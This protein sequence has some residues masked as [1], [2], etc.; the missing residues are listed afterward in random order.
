MTVSMAADR[1]QSPAFGGPNLQE[2]SKP[3]SGFTPL[4]PIRRTS[5][6]D[7]LTRKKLGG[8]ED[9]GTPSPVGSSDNE[10]PPVPPIKDGMNYQNG[11]GHIPSQAHGDQAAAHLNQPHSFHQQPPPQQH[12]A[13]ANGQVPIPNGFPAGRGAAQVNGFHP[14][15]ISMGRGGPVGPHPQFNQMQGQPGPLPM[16]NA[17]QPFISQM[18]GNPIHKFPP[19]GQWKLEESVLSEPLIQHKRPGANSP[20]Q[21]QPGYFALD[22]ETEEASPPVRAQ[23]GPQT[24]PRNNSSNIPPVSAERFRKHNIFAPH[25]PEQ[26]QQQLPPQ[27]VGHPL[28]QGQANNIPNQ[29]ERSARDAGL[30]K[31]PDVRVDEVSVSSVTSEEPQSGGGRRG[32]GFFSLTNRRN[33]GAESGSQNSENASGKEKVSFFGAM[34]NHNKFQPKQK[35]NLGLPRTSTFDHDD[36]PEPASMKKRLSELT[37]MI[38]GVGNAKDGAKDDQPVKPSG[39]YP[40]RPS[41]QGPIRAQTGFQPPQG[42]HGQLGFSGAPSNGPGRSS[43]GGPRPPEAQ[44]SQG[45]DDREKKHGFLG[46]FFNRQGFKSSDSRQ[47]NSPTPPPGQKPPPQFPMQPGQQFRP[48]QMPPPGQGQFGP[49]PM[50]A[51]QPPIQEGLPGQQGMRRPMPPG[52]LN[53]PENIQSPTSPQFLGTAQAVMI[54][55]PSEITVSSQSQVGGSQLSPGQRSQLSQQGSLANIRPGTGQQ[56][57]GEDFSV[58]GALPKEA[59]RLSHQSSRDRL[60]GGGSPLATRTTPTRKPVGS[61]SRPDGTS[62]ASGQ[63]PPNSIQQTPNSTRAGDPASRPESAED[64]RRSSSH[65]PSGQQSPTLG[66]LG[67]VRQTSLP[68][69]GRPPMLSQPGQVTSPTAT[70]AQLSPLGPMPSRDQQGLG[71]QHEMSQG[72][73]GMSQPGQGFAGYPTSLSGANPQHNPRQNPQAWGPNVSFANPQHPVSP[74]QNNQGQPPR[75]V[76][77]PALAPDQQSTISKFFG[78][79]GNGKDKPTRQHPPPKESKEKSAAS[80]FLDAFKRGSKQSEPNPP[81]PQQRPPPG[82]QTPPNMVRTQQANMNM[83]RPPISGPSPAGPL[84]PMS[85]PQGPMQPG[86][87][88]GVPQPQGPPNLGPMGPPM[89]QGAGRGE[90]PPQMQAGR[91]QQMMMVFRPQGPGQG[92]GAPGQRTEPQYDMVPIPRGYEAVHGYGNAGMLAPSPYNV[93]RPSPPPPQP[94][95]QAFVPQGVPQGVPQQWGPRQMPPG[96]AYGQHPALLQPGL[97]GIPPQA[98]QRQTDSESSTPTPSEQGT[99]LDMAPTPPPQQPQDDFRFDRPAGQSAPAPAQAAH[100]PGPQ[101]AQAGAQG[102]P[103]QA[104]NTELQTPS[105]SNWGSAPDSARTPQSQRK[106]DPPI[107]TN[108]LH[109]KPSDPNVSPPS[110]SDDVQRPQHQHIA[111]AMSNSHPSILQPGTPQ[112]SVPNSARAFSPTGGPRLVQ[113]SHAPAVQEPES[114]AGRLVSKMS[115]TA[116]S[117]TPTPNSG[118][119]TPRNANGNGSLSPDILGNRATSVS[120]EPRPY[121]QV[122][123]AS[124]NINV[125]RAN[126]LEKG[127]EDDLY[128]A[129]PRMGSSKHVPAP[130][131]KQQQQHPVQPQQVYVPAQTPIQGPVPVSV[132]GHENTKYAGTAVNGAGIAGVAAGA[133]AGAGL[134]AGVIME[135]GIPEEPTPPPEQQMRQQQ[136]PTSA[137]P[138]EKIL[139]DQPAELPAVHDDDDG[140][141]V[142]SATSYPGQEWNPYGAGEFGDWD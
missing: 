10:I 35:S 16:H 7:L 81:A 21:Q 108:A 82:H 6:F 50:F 60:D 33:T 43:M 89:M 123:N 19:G 29:G 52:Q 1:A 141:P 94:Q 96:V 62:I 63:A 34:S 58:S 47:S 139:V 53:P 66:K 86:Q 24:R 129:T 22:K 83:N 80:K 87:G 112:N 26:S 111:T 84:G 40:G 23:G 13:L 114:Q 31:E 125:E 11:N 127:G 25:A 67:H 98:M 102:N 103:Q 128:D 2:K 59:P 124:L 92:R 27:Q 32:S 8:E 65:L 126:G 36:T 105:S 132:P 57:G 37:G 70:G 85:T 78:I 90:I 38:K 55:R 110:D 9:D 118:E 75:P 44:Q 73:S 135:D 116:S 69:P 136:V 107:L 15:Q 79:D 138:E 42:P 72:P 113:T 14:Q 28:L 121:H 115:A 51:G 68:S 109:S 140:I 77:F 61:S 41:M 99:F 54:R 20:P 76:G 130:P 95:F 45:E 17:G 18:G 56:A 106:P 39:A 131:P 5:T 120:P 4:P 71:Q 91:G 122:S 142:M 12:P 119:A 49:H 137:E 30:N 104:Q 3:V 46:G 64:E 133:G 100:G 88:R 48:G 93:G 134:A 101:Q 74:Y 97:Q 117:S